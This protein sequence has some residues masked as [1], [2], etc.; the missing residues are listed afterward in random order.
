M[1]GAK[2]QPS[3]NSDASSHLIKGTSFAMAT[4]HPQ[5]S[6]YRYGSNRQHGRGKVVHSPFPTVTAAFYHFASSCPENKAIRDLSGPPREMSYG[7][8]ASRV[9][10]LAQQ[11]RR[12]GVA[13][14]QRIPLIVKRSLEMIVG[15]WAI[16]SCGAQYV[17][18]DGGVV[19]DETIRRVL[20]QA[21]GNVVLCLSSTKH[22]VTALSSDHTV[23]AVDEPESLSLEIVLEDG[24]MDLA[25]PDGG[26]YVI[27]TSGTTGQ[28]KGVDIT[29]RSVTNLVCLSPGNLGVTPGTSVGSLLNISF[30]MGKQGNPS[31]LTKQPE[32]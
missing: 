17:P 18:L 19:P 21:Q 30:D 16:L 15:I 6:R 27:Y 9:Q 8:L 11:L 12:Q 29:H 3:P 10:H 14:G 32:G 13:P 5:R 24:Y 2:N 23:V 26:C 4:I 20:D 31:W 1:R 22:R 7:D 25:I 28:P